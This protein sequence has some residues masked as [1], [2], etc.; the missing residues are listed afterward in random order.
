MAWLD[1][2]AA[3]EVPSMVFL[4]KFGGDLADEARQD[5]IAETSVGNR[6]MQ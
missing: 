3:Q 1:P 2:V 5:K 6:L 4:Y